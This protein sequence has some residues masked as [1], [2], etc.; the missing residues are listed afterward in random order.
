MDVL[1]LAVVFPLVTAIGSAILLWFSNQTEESSWQKLFI[2][3]GVLLLATTFLQTGSLD[4]GGYSEE[5]NVTKNY[6]NHTIPSHEVVKVNQ[7]TE[8]STTGVTNYTYTNATKPSYQETLVAN[9]T[10]TCSPSNAPDFNQG[11]LAWFLILAFTFVL[12]LAWFFIQIIGLSVS[13]IRSQYLK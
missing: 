9:K 8:N 10:T 7:T 5:C 12:L 2:G 6:Q 11:H 3:L 13:S 4:L 1:T